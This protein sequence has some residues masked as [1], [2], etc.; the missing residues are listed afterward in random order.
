[1]DGASGAE[2][3]ASSS[4][5]HIRLILRLRSSLIGPVAAR[6]DRV[7]L[8]ADGAQRGHRVLR[9][10]GLQLTAR[11]D[12]R[13]Q[14]DVQEEAA[15]PADLVPDL[16]DRLEEGQAFDVADRAADL[17]DDDVDVRAAHV[18][19][20]GLDLVRD[21]RDD[22]H[23]VTQ[24][25]AAAL[26]GDD[27]RVDLPGRDVRLA[28]QPGVEEPLVVAH[29]QVGL[30]AVV[31]DEDLA[32]LERVHR[33]RVDVEVRVELL[34]GHPQAAHLEQPAE[35]GRGQALAEAGGDA[36]GDEEVLGLYLP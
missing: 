8:D 28:A 26:L 1:M 13:Q 15:V 10:L 32:V 12:V 29:V 35:A 23:R 17:G 11:A 34:H 9:G 18:Q 2:T 31:G 6:H 7:R 24:V 20:A 16:A 4:T 22:L 30:R 19:D 14:R 25:L 27:A 36:A 33:A 21:V 5:S 3:T